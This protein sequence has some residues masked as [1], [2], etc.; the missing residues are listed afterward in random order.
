MVTPSRFSRRALAGWAVAAGV[1]CV[2]AARFGTPP[3]EVVPPSRAQDG[4]EDESRR[5]HKLE[6][7]RTGIAS[8]FEAKTMI[9]AEVVAGRLSLSEAA[10]RFQSIRH[11]DESRPSI[12]RP[13]SP[14]ASEE[15]DRFR[16]VINYIQYLLND[17][18]DRASEVVERLEKELREH[19]TEVVRPAGGPASP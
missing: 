12:P 15:E 13:L 19:L 11:R 14:K 8:R 1:V 17:T 7:E 10:N 6:A 5:G 16:E 2:F 18:P 4:A 9:A 3:G